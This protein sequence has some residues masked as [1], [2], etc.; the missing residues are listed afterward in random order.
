MTSTRVIEIFQ[1]EK[2]GIVWASFKGDNWATTGYAYFPSWSR[3][4]NPI[5]S[6]LRLF[7]VLAGRLEAL[8]K[9]YEAAESMMDAVNDAN[10]GDGDWHKDPDI[11]RENLAGRY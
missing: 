3:K 8:A 6:L 10:L 1:A 2:T 4:A 5:M 7:A 9:V 11:C